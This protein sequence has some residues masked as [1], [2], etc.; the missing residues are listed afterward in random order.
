MDICKRSNVDKKES[1]MSEDAI[2]RNQIKRVEPSLPI[3][4]E[5]SESSSLSIADLTPTLE[6]SSES[7]DG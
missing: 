1:A 2:V 6:A 3:E 5:S 7:S 4:E